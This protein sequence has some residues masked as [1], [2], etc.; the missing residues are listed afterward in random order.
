LVWPLDVAVGQRIRDLPRTRAMSLET[1]AAR[2]DLSIG[3]RSSAACP[4]RRYGCWRLSLTSW[5]WVSQ[6]F[7]RDKENAN[8]TPSGIVTRKRQRANG[9]RRK[10]W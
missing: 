9:A 1:V 5:A 6:G 4:R 3:A 2:T 7:F 8:A 10:H